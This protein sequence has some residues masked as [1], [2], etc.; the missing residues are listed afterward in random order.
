MIKYSMQ[1][2]AIAIITLDRD[3]KRN[4]LSTEMA[5]VLLRSFDR[6]ENEQARVIVL[7]ANDRVKVWCAG[8][9][10]SELDLESLETDNTTLE[11]C[12]K[13]QATPLPVIAMVEGGVYA[14]GLI[15]LLCADIVVASPTAR[16]AITS[17]KLGIPLAPELYAFWLRVMGLHKAK[18]LL[19][20]AATI[21]P[22]DAYN[23]GLFNHV[24]PADQL[25]QVTLSIARKI[26][27]CDSAGVANAKFQLNLIATQSSLDEQQRGHIQ[28][29]N[30]ELISNPA[31]RQRVSAFLKSLGR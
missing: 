30:A 22:E 23:A 24:V 29:R 9:D 18:E 27:D 3:E 25:E 11:V 26:L 17:S 2:D 12:A 8:H 6:A 13:I 28:D 1:G 21:S 19:F 14:G 5:K 7:R 16:V 15:M 31:L 4:A 20:T 10:L